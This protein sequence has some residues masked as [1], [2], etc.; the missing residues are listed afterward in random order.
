MIVSSSRSHRPAVF[1][2][3]DGVI[4]RPPKNRYIT[5]W[6][7]FHFLPGSLEGLRRLAQQRRTVIVISNQAGVGHGLYRLSELRRITRNMLRR[8]RQAGGRVRAVYYC[9]HRPQDH[10]GCRKPKPGMLQ[11]AGR[12]FQI[13]LRRAVLVGD[14][15]TDIQLGRNAGCRTVL[16]WSGVTPRASLNKLNARPD[17]AAPDLR[18]AVDWILKQP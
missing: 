1:L 15:E 18:R 8:I 12:S 17:H 3:R 7:E 16:V 11:K 10:C 4:N 2:D 9:T 5:R 6:R 13:D 14:N